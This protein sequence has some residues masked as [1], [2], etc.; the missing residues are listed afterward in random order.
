MI[1]TRPCFW[2]PASEHGSVSRRIRMH[3]EDCVPATKDKYNGGPLKTSKTSLILPTSLSALQATFRPTTRPTPWPTV[4]PTPWHSVSANALTYRP[5]NASTYH[6]TNASANTSANTLTITPA[7]SLSTTMATNSAPWQRTQHHGNDVDSL[8]RWIIPTS[9]RVS[10]MGNPTLFLIQRRIYFRRYDPFEFFF[11][12]NATSLLVM[13]VQYYF[14]VI[15]PCRS[16]VVL[17][18]FFICRKTW[19]VY[20]KWL[21][22]LQS[23]I[24]TVIFWE[25]PAVISWRGRLA[26]IVRQNE[27]ITN[28]KITVVK[29]R[30]VIFVFGGIMRGSG[31][32][33]PTNKI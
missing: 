6:P 4:R 32:G 11:I 7:S 20:L 21:R 10:A 26:E 17:M 13:F 2:S 30:S 29:V 16:I 18:S 15:M 5:T 24:P 9:C 31:Y 19:V 28:E 33:L 25:P 27:K 22:G 12:C 14:I 3:F 23:M 1:P 8:L